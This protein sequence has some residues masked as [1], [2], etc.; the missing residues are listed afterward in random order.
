MV[1]VIN[2]GDIV[3]ANGKTIRENNLAIQHKYPI[4]TLVETEREDSHGEKRRIEGRGQLY[5]AWHSRDCDGSPLYH[6]SAVPTDK[7]DYIRPEDAF[8]IDQDFRLFL[9]A[10]TFYNIVLNVGEDS[11]RPVAEDGTSRS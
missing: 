8:G 7:W 10:K 5:V 3:E 9:K 2:F 11:L 6:L 1:Q 4:G